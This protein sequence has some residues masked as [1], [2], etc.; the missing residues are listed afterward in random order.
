VS[1][2]FLK[3]WILGGVFFWLFL[4]EGLFSLKLIDLIVGIGLI[5]IGVFLYIILFWGKKLSVYF[6]KI[7]FMQ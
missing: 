3:C 4:S 1:F 6:G 7:S 2:I 5:F